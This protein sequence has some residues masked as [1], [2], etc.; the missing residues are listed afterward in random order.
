MS[1]DY[2]EA[3]AMLRERIEAAAPNHLTADTA[4]LVAG[5][6]DGGRIVAPA[7][8]RTWPARPWPPPASRPA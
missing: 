1:K 6:I 8:P 5:W 7:G 2:D 3:A 4:R